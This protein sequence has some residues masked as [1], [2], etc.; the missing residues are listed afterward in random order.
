MPIDG[1][2][3]NMTAI[4]ISDGDKMLM[5]YRIGSSVVPPSWCGIGGH[6]EEFELNDARACVL[7]ELKE[8][9]DISEN[10]LENINLRYV[11]MRYKNNE[12]RQNYY[13]FANLKPGEKVEMNCNEGKPEWISYDNLPHIEMPYSAKYVLEHYLKTGKNTD[14]IYGGIA[15][16]SGVVFTAMEEF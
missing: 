2:L 10:S 3:R 15:N 1:K 13:F 6:F 7:R 12:I 9:M 11:T 16:A 4:Y 14:C 8:E 5:L